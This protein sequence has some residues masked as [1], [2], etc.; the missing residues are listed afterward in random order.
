RAAVGGA[1]TGEGVQQGRLAGAARAHDGE[2]AFRADGER[3]VVEQG[4]A[5]AVDGDRQVLDVERDLA[6]V[7]VL[8]Q[9]V[10][11]EAERGVADPDDVTGG[12]RGAG[13]GPAVEEGAVVTVEVDDLVRPVHMGAQLRVPTGDDQVVDDHVVVAAAAYADGAAGQ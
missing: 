12:D 13:D 11:D 2:Q 5:A 1:L 6:G 10:A 4:L 9:L 7:D 3:H 8:L